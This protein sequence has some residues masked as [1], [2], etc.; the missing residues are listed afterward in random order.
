MGGGP[1]GAGPGTS[2]EAVLEYLRSS[3]ELIAAQRDVVLGY[4]GASDRTGD[5]P[6]TPDP[7]PAA[8]RDETATGAP[9]GTTPPPEPAPAPADA[10][11]IGAAVRAALAVPQG[12][13]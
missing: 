1:R 11:A 9:P 2:E 3:R 6:P 7:R 5:A 13:S 8:A 10:K 12:A 4:L